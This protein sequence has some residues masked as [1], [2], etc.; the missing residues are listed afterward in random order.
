LRH[1]KCTTST[2]LT[3]SLWTILTSLIYQEM[4]YRYIDII[5][6]LIIF[7]L[8]ANFICSALVTGSYH[9]FQLISQWQLLVNTTWGEYAYC[10]YG[11]CKMGDTHLVGREAAGGLGAPLTGQVTKM[12]YLLEW[13]DD[14][15]MSM[16]YWSVLT[17]GW[18][19]VGIAY[20]KDQYVQR[21][22]SMLLLIYLRDISGLKHNLCFISVLETMAALGRFSNSP[23]F[24]LERTVSPTHKDYSKT[25]NQCILFD[26]ARHRE[27]L[28]RR[29]QLLPFCW[30]SKDVC[31]SVLEWRSVRGNVVNQWREFS[32]LTLWTN[33]E[34]VPRLTLKLSRCQILEAEGV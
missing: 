28:S 7:F 10:N 18:L 6:E 19:V 15:L 31:S 8:Q 4:V 27:C 20:Q 33:R 9:Y 16:R 11:A 14:I 13:K 21:V 5:I 30:C 32:W 17:T 1:W 24:N 22:K 23:R 12:T 25:D 2:E 29:D 3:S 26:R 34:A